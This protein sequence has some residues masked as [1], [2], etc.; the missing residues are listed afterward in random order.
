MEIEKLAT[1]NTGKCPTCLAPSKTKDVKK[2][3]CRICKK[4]GEDEMWSCGAHPLNHLYC[5]E[6]NENHL[7]A[8]LA[9]MKEI[10]K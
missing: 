9:D 6:C 8:A 10:L 3:K 5:D 2:E 7:K 1:T 4:E